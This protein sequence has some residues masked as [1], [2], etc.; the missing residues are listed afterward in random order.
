VP[1]RPSHS[2]ADSG[3]HADRAK[4]WEILDSDDDE[5]DELTTN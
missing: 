5:T 4:P 1:R 3:E 2:G